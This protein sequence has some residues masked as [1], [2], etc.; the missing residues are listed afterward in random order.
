MSPEPCT[1]DPNFSAVLP[2]INVPQLPPREKND[3]YSPPKTPKQI[4]LMSS[5]EVLGM[6]NSNL[7]EFNPT[8]VHIRNF[9][10]LYIHYPN[11]TKNVYDYIFKPKPQVD[12]NQ[13]SPR[14]SESESLSSMNEN[15][16]PKTN[17]ASKSKSKLSTYSLST[18]RKQKSENNP[19]KS[20]NPKS[21]K[22]SNL[23][24]IEKNDNFILRP[25]STLDSKVP[26]D[27]VF[28][29]Y[30]GAKHL[31]PGQYNLPQQKPPVVLDMSNLHDRDC[32]PT[33]KGSQRIYPLAVEQADKLR[34]NKPF[35][36]FST[37]TSRESKVVKN[38]RI[39]MLD[40]FKKEKQDL[41]NEICKK[42]SLMSAKISSISSKNSS[43]NDFNEDYEGK[44]RKIS[45]SEL[46]EDELNY[47]ID[48]RS[49][50]ALKKRTPFDIQSSR[51]SLLPG[52]KNYAN[53]PEPVYQFDPIESFKKMQPEVKFTTIRSRPKPLSDEKFWKTTWYGT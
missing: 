2:T 15:T 26:R 23:I 20:K 4:E 25:T 38:R 41:I 44:K 14:L 49:K 37:D 30:S 9:E 33:K 10:N 7:R 1:Y 28:R 34:P 52:E 6:Y 11:E 53:D 29:N 45:I 3:P 51:P 16:T 21:Y 39:Q 43:E 50:S 27:E 18:S 13:V 24:N 48:K 40:K 32:L 22:R 19:K 47:S 5:T 35:H 17:L 46:A 12:T 36:K 42:S 8:N 31:G